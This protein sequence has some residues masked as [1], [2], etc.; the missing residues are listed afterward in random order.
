VDAVH[1]AW[2]QQQLLPKFAAT[3]E[4]REALERHRGEAVQAAILANAGVAPE[5]TS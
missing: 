5:R 1:A 4:Q 3:Q 2:L